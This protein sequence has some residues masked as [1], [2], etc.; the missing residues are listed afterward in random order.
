MDEKSLQELTAHIRSHVTYP[1]TRKDFLAA[2]EN[3]SHV[4]SAT[5]KWVAE[6]LPDRTY[7][8]SEEVLHTLKLPHTH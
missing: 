4:P 2:C 3:M 7:Q 6:N 1:I 8:S 5:V